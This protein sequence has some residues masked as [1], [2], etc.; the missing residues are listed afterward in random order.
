[1]ESPLPRTLLTVWAHPDDEAYLSAGLMLRVAR[2]GGRVVNLTATR[3]ELGGDG[4][5]TP[6]ALAERRTAELEAALAHLGVH[7]VRHFDYP[8][9]GCDAI[10]DAEG[11]AAVGE[12]MDEVRP[13]L[14]VTFGPDGITG[15]PDHIAVSRWTTNAWQA[16]SEPGSLVYATTTPE[17]VQRH[18]DIHWRLGV[19]P[20]G[21][22]RPS[23]PGE[24]L[25]DVHL[26]DEELAVK[27]A[28]LAAHA[29]QTEGLAAQMGEPAFTYWWASESFRR[30]RP[31]ELAAT[32]AA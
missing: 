14:V 7:E 18:A 12:V 28:S 27:R 30:P 1:M 13:D 22:P 31:S 32:A 20:A 15:H 2:S 11:A 17:F 6:A 3:G 8:D 16:R 29:S 21:Y 25:F 9:G 19:F 5:E 26:D 24:V 4:S 23:L 10:S